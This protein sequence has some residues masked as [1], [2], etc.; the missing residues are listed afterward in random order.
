MA[1]YSEPPRRES[2]TIERIITLEQQ[3]KYMREELAA[4]FAEIRE[5]LKEIKDKDLKD[6]KDQTTRTNG[7]VTGLEDWKN[8]LSYSKDGFQSV[9]KPVWS[10]VS[11]VAVG[12]ITAFLVAQF[13]TAHN[14]EA[15]TPR[16][17]P[18]YDQNGI[19]DADCYWS[20]EGRPSCTPIQST[21]KK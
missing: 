9:V 2:P 11:L 3:F 20:G 13:V 6:I 7:R 5:D 12:V 4:R 1:D 8:K 16:M 21:I 10:I 17:W 19:H 14:S 18:H 15:L